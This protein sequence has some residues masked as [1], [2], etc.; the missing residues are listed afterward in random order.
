MSRP[1]IA[2]AQTNKYV[3]SRPKK[4]RPIGRPT[5]ALRSC[6]FASSSVA[7][8]S[9]GRALASPYR[10]TRC[11]ESAPRK[12]TTPIPPSARRNPITRRSSPWARASSARNSRRSSPTH[13]CAPPSI[14]RARRRRMSP[15][16][17]G[18]TPRNPF[19]E[20]DEGRR[21]GTFVACA[22]PDRRERW[23]RELGPPIARTG[24]F[25]PSARRQ[26]PG[27]DSLC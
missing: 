7:S 21:L 20:T 13:G 9:A 12:R 27:Y 1:P 2:R 17:T 23:F 14:R 18:S 24:L 6:E 25:P 4:V 15:R 19:A 5:A 22:K 3:D 16:S 8:C 26:Y 11:R 10:R